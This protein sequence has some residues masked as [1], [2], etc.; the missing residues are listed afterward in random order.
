[1]FYRV[2]L[3]CKANARGSVHS[4]QDHFISTLIITTDVTDATL[5]A[6]GLWL[7]TRTG[8]GGTT[9]LTRVF[10]PQ[11]MASWATDSRC[12]QVFGVLSLCYILLTFNLMQ[13]SSFS[14]YIGCFSYFLTKLYYIIL[15]FIVFFSLC[16]IFS[17][18]PH[19]VMLH[20]RWRVF[21]ALLD[22]FAV[23]SRGYAMNM[24]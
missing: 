24:A 1:M 10:W 22:V 23:S 11:P 14:H 20:C 13:M 9:T 3:S 7:G 21:P 16:W 15:P 17:L 2:F 6:S 8:V 12:M 4:P 5:G 18:F 19:E